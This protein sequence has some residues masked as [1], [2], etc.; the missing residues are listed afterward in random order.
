MRGR[1]PSAFLLCFNLIGKVCPVAGGFAEKNDRFQMMDD[2]Y[3]SSEEFLEKLKLYEEAQKEGR[4]VFIEPDFLADIAEY[5]HDKGRLEEAIKAA[6]IGVEM[7]P[8]AVSPLVF[9]ARIEL[10]ERENPEKARWY[11]EQV[12]EKDDPDYTYLM[13]EILIFEE[14]DEEAEA[15]LHNLYEDLDEDEREDFVLDV[16]NIYAEYN[17]MDVAQ[18]WLSLANDHESTDYQELKGRIAVGQGKYE[19]GEQIYKNLVDKEPFSTPY[20][21]Q[22]ASS[23]FMRNRI[24]ES[25]ESSE[26]SIAI[27]PDDEEAVLNK[28]NGMYSLGNYEEALTYYRRFKE[29]HSQDESGDILIGST[30]LCLGRAEEALEQLQKAEKKAAPDSENLPEI[31]KEMAFALSKLE[32]PEEAIEYIDKI[33]ATGKADENEMIVFKGHIMLMSMRIVEAQLYFMDAVQRANFSSSIYARICASIYDTGIYSLAYKMY[34]ILFNSVDK[35]WPEGHAQ[36]ARCCHEL[37]KEDEFLEHLQT[38]CEVNPAE[39]R[40]VLAELFPKDMN[41]EEYYHYYITQKG[42]RE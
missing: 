2:G 40:F 7:F 35:N 10:F 42:K 31:Y 34:T 19:Q 16:A 13:A 41:P 11:A 18:Q 20:W 25:I 22:L 6:E 27:N 17:M 29:L 36:M 23:Q 5:Y 1:A 28:A 4:N 3:F 12:E 26:F 15:Y 8:G 14:K 24:P 9:M 37:E 32:R 33:I 21:N 30:L 38:A 39:A